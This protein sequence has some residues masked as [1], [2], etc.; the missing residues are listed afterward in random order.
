MV[1]TRCGIVL[2]QLFIVG[3]D[4]HAAELA[5]MQRQHAEHIALAARYGYLGNREFAFVRDQRL[6]TPKLMRPWNERRGC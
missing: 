4:N 2:H 3:H 6:H 5:V 1:P